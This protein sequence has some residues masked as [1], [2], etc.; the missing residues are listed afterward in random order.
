MEQLKKCPFCGGETFEYRLGW[1]FPLCEIIC[2]G[3]GCRTGMMAVAD[4]YAAWNTRKPMEWYEELESKLQSLYGECD[5]FLETVVDG[6]VDGLINHEGVQFEKLNKA[7]LLTNENVEKWNRLE[8]AKERI[9]ERL[10]EELILAD[11][12][13]ERCIKENPL[14][15]DSAKGYATGV[16]KSIEIVKEEM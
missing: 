16:W 5:G 12:E 14:Q 11:R 13:K 8:G 7:L 3:C 10:E 6:V 4:A 1:Q 2:K 15:F 9:V